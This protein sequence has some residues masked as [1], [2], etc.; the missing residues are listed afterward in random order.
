MSEKDR[1]MG[2][3]AL[4]NSEDA[5]VREKCRKE[6]REM[7]KDA[8]PFLNRAKGQ[9]A[10]YEYV[11]VFK[12]LAEIGDDLFFEGGAENVGR[13]I[14]DTMEYGARSIL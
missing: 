10:P 11:E 5:A 3:I 4:L 6:I 9:P 14:I 7:G 1:T 8:I 12:M 2:L 13:S